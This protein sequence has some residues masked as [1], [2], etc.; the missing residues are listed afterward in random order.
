MVN[1]ATVL[2]GSVLGLLFRKK[3]NENLTKAVI[4]ALAPVTILIGLKSALETADVLCVIICMAVGTVIGSLLRIDDGIECAGDFLK[5]KL[6]RGNVRE[7][8]FTEGFVTAC[9]VFGVDK[10]KRL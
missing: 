2:L 9:I 1:T 10:A 4:S 6:L 7:N 8:R 5:N 3:I